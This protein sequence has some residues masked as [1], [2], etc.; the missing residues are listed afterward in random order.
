MSIKQHIHKYERQKI[1]K[2]GHEIF[3]C[4]L[5]ECTHN[6]PSIELAVGRLSLCW[7][8]CGD[9]VLINQEMYSRRIVHPMCDKCKAEKIRRRREL[10]NL[11]M[12]QT[13][14]VE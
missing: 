13:E 2:N 3:R 4:M 1:G 10:D 9:A 11:G 8:G 5:P 12:V 7:G 6:L 14:E